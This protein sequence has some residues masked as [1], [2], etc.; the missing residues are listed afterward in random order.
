MDPVENFELPEVILDTIRTARAESYVMTAATALWAYDVVMALPG[1][2]ELLSRGFTISDIVYWAARLTL[3]GFVISI[4]NLVPII[5]QLIPNND[6]EKIV[7]ISEWFMVLSMILN[8]LL[9]VFRVRAVYLNSTKVTVIFSLL[10]LMTLSQLLPPIANE[11]HISNSAPSTDGCDAILN[12]KPW[13]VTGFILTAIF[14]TAV[15]VA[16]SMQ[17]AWVHGWDTYLEGTD[18]FVPKWQRAR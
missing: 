5:A 12:M 9:F 18:D 4:I 6:C 16:I 11:L 17:G 7:P 10:W 15:F 1:E 13:V 14:D 8:S 2:L 3:A